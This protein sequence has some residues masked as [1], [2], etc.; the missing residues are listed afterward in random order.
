MNDQNLIPF[1]KRT[2]SE[3]RELGRK[4]GIASGEARRNKRLLAEICDRIG[5]QRS[6]SELL[7]DLPEDERTRD[8]E[9]VV[10]QYMAAAA[11]DTKAA[12]WVRDTKGESSV[13]VEMT[14]PPKIE[15]VKE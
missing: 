15:F 14:A 11:G 4:G 3:A 9:V 5:Q 8:A 2:E 10:A 7:K 12:Q 13:R 6:D 1:D